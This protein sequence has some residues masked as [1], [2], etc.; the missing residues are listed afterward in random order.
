MRVS[1]EIGFSSNLIS[2][3]RL[4]IKDFGNS[5][6]TN[7]NISTSGFD[8]DMYKRI[9]RSKEYNRMYNNL[10]NLLKENNNSGN[11]IDINVEM[12]TDKTMNETLNF[13]DYQ[14][15]LQYL[16]AKKFLCKF[17]YD[18]WVGKIKQSELSGTMKIRNMMLSM[19][20]RFSACFEYS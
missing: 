14:K 7:M 18:D 6:I 17:R 13:P 19:R 5:G 16:P 20:F 9:Y 1:T 2:L 4:T 11:P 8:Q 12:R 10:T 3:A 15:L